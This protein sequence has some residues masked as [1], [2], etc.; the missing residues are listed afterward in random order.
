MEILWGVLAILVG[1]GILL[2][3]FE[4][5]VRQPDTLVLYEAKDKIGLR[6]GLFYPRHFSLLLKRAPHPIQ[7]HIEGVAAG[8]LG[9][10]VKL[11]GSVAPA[12]DN[13]SALIRIGGWNSDAVA[14]AAEQAS[15][16]LEGLVKEYAQQAEIQ[17]LSSKGLSQYLES[18]TADF[19]QR[20]GLE[21][22]SLA[23][24]SL[25]PADSDIAEALR[26]Q[27]EARLM[28]QTEKLNN[29]ARIAAA[30]SKYQADEEIAAMEHE[31]EL[32]KLALQ[33][34]RLAQEDALA[35][36]R[37]E[38]EL[39][40]NR[41]RL[42]FEKEELDILKDNPEL[43]ILTPQAARLAEASQALKNARTVI[44]LSPQDLAGTE[45]GELFQKLLQKAVEKQK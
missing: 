42:A 4:F 15:I 5:R 35:Q 23:V 31:L 1:A 11:V 34:E 32:K 39:T 33:R 22:I 29:Q 7:L 38:D 41:M 16:R 3:L 17:S 40:R 25:D 13:L 19:K 2:V 9:V 20:F 45:W 44:S 28:E 12:L 37:L 36:K 18:Q 21:V 14:R 30:R 24:V 27:E 43:L 6:Q 26:Q 10:V 8:N